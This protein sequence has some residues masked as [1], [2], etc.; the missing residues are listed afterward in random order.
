MKMI[1]VILYNFFQFLFLYPHIKTVHLINS[2][3]FCP[4]LIPDWCFWFYLLSNYYSFNFA[5]FPNFSCAYKIAFSSPFIKYISCFNSVYSLSHPLVLLSFSPKLIGK[6][7]DTNFSCF[8]YFS[9]EFD[10]HISLPE[11]LSQKKN[12]YRLITKF[13]VFHN[14]HQYQTVYNIL[15]YYFSLEMFFSFGYHS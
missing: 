3:I 15:H 10:L 11:L 12:H 6:E 7:V 2:R 13:K 5:S 14:N 4:T 9:L 1:K 8:F